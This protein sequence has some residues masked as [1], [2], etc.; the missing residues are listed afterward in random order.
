MHPL[1]FAKYR[2]PVQL[3][4][5]TAAILST[6]FPVL[7]VVVIIRNDVALAAEPISD[8]HA[9]HAPLDPVAAVPAIVLRLNS[10]KLDQIVE[11][12]RIKTRNPLDLFRSQRGGVPVYPQCSGCFTQIKAG[13]SQG[14]YNLEIQLIHLQCPPLRHCI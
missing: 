9:I 13:V 6:S 1:R 14:S 10:Q 5:H 4:S 8:L 11:L 7:A 3:L 2:H 12:H